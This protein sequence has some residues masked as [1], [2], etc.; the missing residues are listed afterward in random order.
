MGMIEPALKGEALLA[1]I[2]RAGEEADALNVWW[3][4]QSGFLLQYDGSHLLLDP[5]LSDSLTRKYAGTSKP[6]T[7]MTAIPI[8]PRRLDFIDGAVSTHNHTDHLDG[9][10]LGPLLLANERMRLAV[11]A[12]NAAFAADR[13][14]CAP[15]D[16]VAVDAGESVS[17]GAFRLSAV[18]AAHEALERDALGR[19]R[20]LGYAAEAGGRAVYHSGDTV[21][22]AGM[23]DWLR[24][25]DLDAAFLPIN[26]R[27]PSRGVAGN[28][29]G[30]EA[31]QL[32]H[33]LGVGTAVPCHYEMFEFNTAAPDG[34]EAACERLGQRFRTLRCGERW[35]VPRLSG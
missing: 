22:Y 18:P 26:G 19:Y 21:R 15:S 20:H 4:G 27:D 10:T 24:G 35:T 16:L 14:G 31:A 11:P 9:E 29:S 5:Y 33:D 1:D 6:H 23:L 12:A 32:A 17:I 3:L 28:L 13:L 34:F 7:R 8:D 2:R 30:E 25:W